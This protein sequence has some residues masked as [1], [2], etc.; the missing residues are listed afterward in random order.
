MLVLWR[1]TYLMIFH[2][3]SPFSPLGVQLPVHELTKSCKLAELDLGLG[4]DFF[5]LKSFHF[6]ILH[7][8]NKIKQPLV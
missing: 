4:S 8:E 1:V 2:V 6:R 7:L 5:K 3:F